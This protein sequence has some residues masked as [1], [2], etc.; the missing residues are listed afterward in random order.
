MIA[1]TEPLSIALDRAAKQSLAAQIHDALR[2]AIGEGTLAAGAR[3]PS[4]R[5]LAA[6]LGVARG[7]VRVAYERLADEQLIEGFGA[8]GT[9][10]AARPP[11]AA[12]RPLAPEASP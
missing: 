10:V 6:Q 11:A 3:L 8:A 1:M 7:T 5:D 2:K 9:R 12:K 4:W